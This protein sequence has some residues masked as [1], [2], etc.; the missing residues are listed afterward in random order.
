M[1]VEKINFYLACAAKISTANLLMSN[2]FYPIF[3]VIALNNSIRIFLLRYICPFS[4]RFFFFFSIY[5]NFA[6]YR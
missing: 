6:V 5:E 4:V 1:E 2:N 3:T